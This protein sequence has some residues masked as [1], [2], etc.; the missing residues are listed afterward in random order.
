M[1]KLLPFLK[2]KQQQSGVIVQNRTPDEPKDSEDQGLMA[3]AQD[4]I[5]AVHAKDA[6]RVASALKA[7]FEI[8]DSEPHVEG[9]HLDE[10]SPHTYEAQNRKAAE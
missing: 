10:S 1:S 6:K 3:C 8:A 7:A 9:E 5:D 2:N 4:L